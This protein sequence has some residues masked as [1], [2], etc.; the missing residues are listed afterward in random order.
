[1]A[2]PRQEPLPMT[3]SR[4]KLARRSRPRARQSRRR[5][6][7]SESIADPNSIMGSQADL[8]EKIA[9]KQAEQGDATGVLAWAG[10]QKLPR[11]KLHPLRGMADGIVQRVIA[12]S[13]K[14]P[15]SASASKP[16]S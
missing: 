15:A 16:A 12:G 10:G 6:V 13:S 1:M 7:T 14:A 5:R 9:K 4:V 3:E 11:S 8:L 2:F